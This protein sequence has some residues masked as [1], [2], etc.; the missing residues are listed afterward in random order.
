MWQGN[1]WAFSY[2][3][4]SKWKLGPWPYTRLF[5][6]ENPLHTHWLPGWKLNPCFQSPKAG[7]WLLGQVTSIYRGDSSTAFSCLPGVSFLLSTVYLSLDVRVEERVLSVFSLPIKEE[8]SSSALLKAACG[9]HF[10][11]FSVKSFDILS[12][13]HFGFLI[14]SKDFSEFFKHTA[15]GGNLGILGLYTCLSHECLSWL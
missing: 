4:S 7:A 14:E 6:E 2:M 1:F 5:Q 10:L 12:W 11:D 9:D 3:I 13:H 8:Y 15:F